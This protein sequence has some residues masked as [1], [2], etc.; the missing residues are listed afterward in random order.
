MIY[1][2]LHL[3][4]LKYVCSDVVIPETKEMYV[5]TKL[6]ESITNLLRELTLIQDNSP[7]WLE[8]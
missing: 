7:A 1:Q 2:G 8:K 3:K 4:S 5:S 6:M